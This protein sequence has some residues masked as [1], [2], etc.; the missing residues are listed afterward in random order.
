MPQNVI[1]NPFAIPQIQTH[2]QPQLPKLGASLGA[3]IKIQQAEAAAAARAARAASGGGG[4]RGRMP[5]EGDP[6]YGRYVMV[7]QKDGKKKEVWVWGQGQK[8]R[9]AAEAKVIGEAVQG[10]LKDDKELQ[11][12]LAGFSDKSQPGQKE[13]LEKLRQTIIPRLSG[14]TGIS[15]EELSKNITTPL[16]AE[17]EKRKKAIEGAGLGTQLA[18]AGSTILRRGIDA[19]ASL[20]ESSE[21]QL[22]RGKAAAEAEA[23]QIKNNAWRDELS[24]L[25]RENRS[26]A[27][28]QFSSPGRSVIMHGAP[29]A[30]MI[31]PAIAGGAIGTVVAPGPGTLAGVI[32]GSAGGAVGAGA[33]ARGEALERVASDP[34]LTEQQKLESV[35]PTA[36]LSTAISAGLGAI[37]IGPANLLRPMMVR[38]AI[39]KA[40]PE[41]VGA[42]VAEHMLPTVTAA[43]RNAAEKAFIDA[44]K[45]AWT[46]N[47]RQ[48]VALHGA[49][50]AALGGAFQ[51][52]S[53]AAYGL[54]TD[55]PIEWMKGVPEAALAGAA[56]GVPFGI[57][58]R[59][60]Q[61]KRKAGLPNNAEPDWINLDG[62]KESQRAAQFRADQSA[63]RE[64]ELG[65]LLNGAI[66]NAAQRR[67]L[68]LPEG[69]AMPMGMEPEA[70]IQQRLQ[71]RQ[72]IAQRQSAAQQPQSD[73]SLPNY[74]SQESLRE[75]P[76]QRQPAPVNPDPLNR[77]NRRKAP[78][79]ARN[80]VLLGN[81]EFLLS[82]P[83]AKDFLYRIGSMDGRYPAEIEDL[84]RRGIERGLLTRA[85][86]ESIGNEIAESNPF[87]QAPVQRALE[88]AAKKP[89]E[90]PESAPKKSTES[91]E[92]GA[93]TELPETDRAN[94]IN[95]HLK[96]LEKTPNR[97]RETRKFLEP[98]LENG[99]IGVEALENLLPDAKASDPR[100]KAI[101]KLKVK[102]A[103]NKTEAEQ[104]ELGQQ[105]AE[106]MEAIENGAPV[107]ESDGQ[108]QQG[109]IDA[110]NPPVD[111]AR[112]AG[113]E[114]NAGAA[115]NPIPEPPAKSREPV[116]KRG[117]VGAE[118]PTAGTP[119]E[120][121]GTP[122][123]QKPAGTESPVREPGVESAAA[124]DAKGSEGAGEPKPEEQLRAR[125]A[126]N[127]KQVDAGSIKEISD[128]S[129][130]E[131]NLASDVYEGL[132]TGALS[133]KVVSDYAKTLTG[134]DAKWRKTAIE[135]A[136]D[137]YKSS[138]ELPATLAGADKTTLKDIR[139][140]TKAQIKLAANR[141]GTPELF[142][143]VAEALKKNKWKE[144]N[145][146]V[147]SAQLPVDPKAKKFLEELAAPKEKDAPL[148]KE[149]YDAFAN[150]TDK[151][152]QKY[153][154]EKEFTP[155]EIVELAGDRDWEEIKSWLKEEGMLDPKIG[156]SLDKLI[157]YD[158]Q[159][160]AIDAQLEIFHDAL[161][162]YRDNP[163]PENLG[164]VNRHITTLE[165]STSPDI[166]QAIT[167]AKE[168]L[169]EP[170]AR[171]PLVSNGAYQAELDRLT[172]EIS[173][174]L[175]AKTRPASIEKAT[176]AF[177]KAAVG[178]KLT[179]AEQTVYNKLKKAGVSD[180]AVNLEALDAAVQKAKDNGFD[181]SRFDIFKGNSMEAGK[182]IR[183]KPDRPVCS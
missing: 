117:N 178:D 46:P 20:F 74:T 84:V 127:A 36:N 151:A 156:K 62:T 65:L 107:M 124:P 103:P 101:S 53:N 34:N 27:G 45:A 155:Q 39:K 172:G 82:N 33:M 179:K 110:E 93:I 182:T 6:R 159:Q 154:A 66:A 25:E 47:L 183:E 83:Q 52:G 50:A 122:V 92:A 40:I 144:A 115:A 98:L 24:R 121:A 69:N 31:A 15:G 147:L 109:R 88:S 180:L 157:D 106:E 168:T 169:G 136:L 54:G 114:S 173:A 146:A 149:T 44:Q 177:I 37:P 176:D 129:R 10:I 86:A 64:G 42:R 140:Y 75:S 13:T 90:L 87:K 77:L 131:W 91:P 19:I 41:G 1:G 111:S 95:E 17:H 76:F 163:T 58:G 128:A 100:V 32:G 160:Q 126:G 141:H 5:Q 43:E 96:G 142:T 170:V 68:A 28:F 60:R 118:P 153:L 161:Q 48:Q 9:D 23:Q 12:A 29:L 2:I 56:L 11:D 59:V 51:I 120:V 152:L 8:E 94:A 30:A 105:W 72:E 73:P 14:V 78:Q 55:Q 181:V 89:A 108:G 119:E 104:A 70:A 175:G 158:R 164:L 135:S 61:R 80:N 137:L 143:Q 81:G 35:G 22:A 79:A 171:A 134:K 150:K 165:K 4:G 112:P 57:A 71:D 102:Y 85:E 162:K 16:Q 123:E 116:E 130:S 7:P 139:D 97:G 132:Y 3:L 166:M 138:R 63:W 38:G 67:P 125:N 145:D 133:E 99:V 18:D 49:N 26:T 148:T 21:E 113:A 167:E 174:N